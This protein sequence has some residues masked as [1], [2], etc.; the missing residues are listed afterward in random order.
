MALIVEELVLLYLRVMRS[1]VRLLPVQ[2]DHL[3][4]A[5]GCHLIWLSHPVH[6]I[7]RLALPWIYGTKMN[8]SAPLPIGGRIR[9]RRLYQQPH[10]MK[11][12]GT[13][14]LRPLAQT[15]LPVKVMTIFDVYLDGNEMLPSG[16]IMNIIDEKPF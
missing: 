2:Q 7:P 1:K 12:T 10:Q 16:T 4:E 5:N 9:L 6:A 11:S 13:S 8:V 15:I 14:V 3:Q